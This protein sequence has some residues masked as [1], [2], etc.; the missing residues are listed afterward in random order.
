MQI[1]DKNDIAP[2]NFY[3]DGFGGVFLKML[4]DQNDEDSKSAFTEQMT[5]LITIPWV[6]VCRDFVFQHPSSP[7]GCYCFSNG[8]G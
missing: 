3:S 4:K 7:E 5:I 1:V 8:A 2:M 6:G